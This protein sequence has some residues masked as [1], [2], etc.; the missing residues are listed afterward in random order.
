MA[1]DRN[2][3][4]SIKP[5][6]RNP[7]LILEEISPLATTTITWKIVEKI[8]LE[9]FFTHS[10][11]LL[12]AGE[13][14][15][16]N[17]PKEQ[18]VYHKQLSQ[19]QNQLHDAIRAEERISGMLENQGNPKRIKRAWF[20]GVRKAS[21]FL[22][23][24]LD[25][26]SEQELKDLIKVS[27]ND[28]KELANLVANQTELISTEF[29]IIRAKA[30]DLESAIN[31]IQHKQTEMIDNAVIA[32][33]VELLTG[34]IL[35]YE[36]DIETLTDAMLFATQGAVHPKLVSPDQIEKSAVL[37]LNAIPD[38]PQITNNQ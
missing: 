18:C 8:D 17:C 13:M 5:I 2:I 33:A 30:V 27:A 24:T 31:T 15:S 19:L 38:A 14:I 3:E 26:D 1:Y 34:N 9:P 12:R 25:E 32:A 23:G 4:P 37:V 20:S 22:F 29:G 28:T 35:Q 16:M 11:T 10:G 36:L 6:H 21:K 7:G